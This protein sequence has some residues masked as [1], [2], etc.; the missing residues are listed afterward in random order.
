MKHGSTSVTIA[1]TFE[2]P[3]HW[4][5]KTMTNGKHV[6]TGA[7]TPGGELVIWHVVRI[8]LGLILSRTNR[9]TNIG[10]SSVYPVTVRG[11]TKLTIKATRTVRMSSY[12]AVISIFLT[13]RLSL[14]VVIRGTPAQPKQVTNRVT[15]RNSRSSVFNLS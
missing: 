10:V 3:L 7:M 6:T 12:I 1:L 15:S 5:V 8:V 11:T 9:G 14:V 2:C 13:V 4:V